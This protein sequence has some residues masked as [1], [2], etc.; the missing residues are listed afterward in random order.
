M[1]EMTKGEW[2]KAL[3]EGNIG[4]Q[5]G[6]LSYLWRYNIINGKFEVK[7]LTRG[8]W[9][10]HDTSNVGYTK[11]FSIVEEEE[12]TLAAVC[13]ELGRDIKIVQG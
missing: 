4:K 5:S 6:N 10:S 11:K 3:I 2:L 8:T 13:E 9:A 7:E 12:M 1:K